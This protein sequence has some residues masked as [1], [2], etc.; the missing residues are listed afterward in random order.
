MFVDMYVCGRIYDAQKVFEKML[1]WNLVT[2]ISMIGG[3]AR[4]MFLDEALEFFHKIPEWSVI[5]W[6]SIIAVYSIHKHNKEELT[7]FYEMQRSGI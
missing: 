3:Y 5:Y 6:T 2:L 7:P 4:N 1:K